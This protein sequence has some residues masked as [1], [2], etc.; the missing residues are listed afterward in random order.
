MFPVLSCIQKELLIFFSVSIPLSPPNF[1][2]ILITHNNRISKANIIAISKNV[3]MLLNCSLMDQTTL[4]K[5]SSLNNLKSC[6]FSKLKNSLY[7][8]FPYNWVIFVL[9]E[10]QGTAP[11]KPCGC[12]PRNWLCILTPMSTKFAF[13]YK[14]CSPFLT[15]H[16]A[17]WLYMILWFTENRCS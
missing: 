11:W 15:C 5:R 3:N 2:V 13:L 6:S 10:S 17:K 8:R 9:L 4:E 1:E 12:C 7:F 16:S 14:T